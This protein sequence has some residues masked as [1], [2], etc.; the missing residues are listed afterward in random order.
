[1]IRSEITLSSVR[2]K[3]LFDYCESGNLI[4][5][6]FRSK[7][8]IGAQL[9][10]SIDKDGYLKCCVDKKYYRLHRLIYFWHFGIFP[11]IVDHVDRNILNNKISNLRGAT[12]SQNSANRTKPNKII[13]VKKRGNKFCAVTFVNKKSKHIG[14]FETIE[15]AGRAYDSYI[16]KI[17]GDFAVTNF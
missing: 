16:K 14:T 6:T 5:K 8:K 11:T 17:H 3:E 1:M 13:G 12:H 10:C 2:I 15:Q 9:K 7:N 4:E